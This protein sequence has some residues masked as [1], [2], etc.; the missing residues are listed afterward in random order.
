MIIKLLPPHDAEHDAYDTIADDL[1]A[2]GV[3][4]ILSIL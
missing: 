2:H 1:I 4:S 3:I